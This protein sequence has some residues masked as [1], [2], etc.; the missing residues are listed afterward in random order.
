MPSIIEET[1]EDKNYW[2]YHPT[3][4]LIIINFIIIKSMH[5]TQLIINGWSY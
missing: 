1:A 3:I 5:P 4:D 2:V